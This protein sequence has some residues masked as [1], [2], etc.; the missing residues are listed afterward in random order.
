MNPTVLIND[1]TTNLAIW[2]PIAVVC[3]SSIVTGLSNYPKASGFIAA[4]QKVLG[5]LS[6]VQ[7]IDSPQSTAAIKFPL[8]PAAAPIREP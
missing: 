7:H 2:L 8:H 1:L 4:L 5:V 3:V 6:V